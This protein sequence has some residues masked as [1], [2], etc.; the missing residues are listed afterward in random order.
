MTQ[1]Q[2]KPQSGSD[3]KMDVSQG[4]SS[5]AASGVVSGIFGVLLG[6]FMALTANSIALWADAAA[7]VL[8]F[9]AVFIA[10]WGLKK[11][12]KGKTEIFN[13][14]FGRF[15]SLTSM[16][17]AALM[18]VSFFIISGAAYVRFQNPIDV[19]GLG[20]IIGIPGVF[21]FGIINCRLLLGSLKLEKHKKTALITAQRRLYS[22]KV[23]ANVLLFSSLCISYFL[24][25]YA[26]AGYSDPI[27][28]ILIALSLLV[29]ASKMFRF[30]VRDLLDCAVEE[31]AQLLILRDLA[32]HFDDFEQILEIRSRCSGGKVYVEVFLEFSPAL[33]HGV[34]ME[35][36]RALQAKIKKHIQCD[37]VLIIP[38]V[39]SKNQLA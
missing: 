19:H 21:I 4:R 39:Q 34:V 20:V 24:S 2:E 22:I 9:L 32:L 5:V 17:M 1:K 36:I 28:A 14:G 35:T 8:D 11:T 27:V 33:K 25:D 13:Y 23:G 3:K 7:T 30:S 6:F 15:E 10:W 26:W 31:Q 12:E 29:G 16:A 18:V 37:E 38:S